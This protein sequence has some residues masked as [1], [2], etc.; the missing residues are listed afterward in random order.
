MSGADPEDAQ[1]VLASASPRRR[2]LLET[3]GLRVRVV[4]AGVD[5]TA[6]PGEGPEPYVRRVAAAKARAVAVRPGTELP[7]LGSDT[8]VTLDGAILGKPRDR[9]EALAML[10]QLSG[11]THEVLTAVALAAGGEVQVRVSRSRVRFRSIPRAE[12][13]AY[14]QTG[15]GRD[16][17]GAYGIQGI[18]GIFAERLD[19]SFS[20]VMGLPVAETEL[21][22][23]AAGV[24][25]WRHRRESP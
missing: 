2:E 9:D 6:A 17:A 16:K 14:W 13:E 25:V 1:L 10:G 12:A 21:L 4:P 20:G 8:T 3:L 22:L 18:G 15:E 24:D 19:G 5:E 23:R 11:R 7:V